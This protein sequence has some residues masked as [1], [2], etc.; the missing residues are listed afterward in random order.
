[1]SDYNDWNKQIIAQFRA[2]GGVGVAMFGDGLLLLTTVGA[3]SGQERTTPLAYTRDGERYVI[4]ASKAGAPTNPD[5][6]YNLRHHPVAT[7][8]V[9][10]ETFQARSTE[11]NGEKHDQLYNN[12]A[13]RFPTFNEYRLKTT[14]VI[15]VLVLERVAGA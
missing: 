9:G 4:I 6:Y 13:A 12:H 15:P 14:R 2:K 3:K 10:G 8:E 11:V 7:V 5:W 1:V